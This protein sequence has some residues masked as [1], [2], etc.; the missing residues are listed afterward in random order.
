MV[1]A[2]VHCFCAMEVEVEVEVAVAV[3]VAVVRAGQVAV[4][5]STRSLSWPIEQG[6]K[7]RFC[8]NKKFFRSPTPKLV[9]ESSDSTHH[10]LLDAIGNALN[11]VLYHGPMVAMR[12][13]VTK[14]H[15]SPMF[16][17]GIPAHLDDAVIDL[18]AIGL[19]AGEGIKS[20]IPSNIFALQPATYLSHSSS[21]TY[22]VSQGSYASPPHQA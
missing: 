4:A 22:I 21:V 1:A 5:L 12:F 13:V 17:D 18:L 8:K 9:H 10:I 7:V 19:H 6:A 3:A 2:A 11:D 15:H 16:A 14:A 20:F